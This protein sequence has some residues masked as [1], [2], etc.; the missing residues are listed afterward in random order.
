[1]TAFRV[2]VAGALAASGAMAAGIVPGDARRGEQLFQTEHCIQCH[3]VNGKGGTAA[4]DLGRRVD[5]NFTPSTMASL[6]WNHAPTMWAAMKQQNLKP[7]PLSSA[8]AADLFA[9]FMS[10][11]YF[12]KPGDAARG[13]QAF[14]DK[15]CVECHGITTS[16]AAGAPPVAKWDSLSDPL[17]MAQQMWNHG[18]RMREE[19]AKKKIAWQRITAQE[20]TDM[21]V[22]LQNLPETRGLTR[23]VSF[24]ASDEGEKLFQSKGCTGCH[25]GK[26]AL[27]SRLHNQTLTE[28][29]VDMWNHQPSM[30]NP[31]PSLSA[32]EMRQII[33]FIWARQYFSSAGNAEHGKKVY[34]EKNCAT[35]HESG[36][37]PKLGSAPGGYSQITM[38][39]ALWAHGPRM[40]ELMNEKKLSW[41][42]LTP[43]QMSDL[44]A[45]LNSQK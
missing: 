8:A 28:I 26:L 39:A 18:P 15:H 1:M 29:A 36:T 14:A 33:S 25:T 7:S 12:E 45:F 19:F 6:M 20:L 10:A 17:V 38:V 41:P 21:L 24:A 3:S 34:T 9:Y 43:P 2:F 44:I 4:P 13:K 27:E 11:R 31:P 23:T 37:A 35:C 30:K 22:Y 40:L 5:R 32:D 42:Q 16:A